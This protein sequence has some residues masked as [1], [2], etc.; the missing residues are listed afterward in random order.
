MSTNAVPLQNTIVSASG[1]MEETGSSLTKCL[2]DK[3]EKHVKC[4]IM[5]SL[6][7]TTSK[8]RKPFYRKP[9]TQKLHSSYDDTRS[10]QKMTES[11]NFFK[12]YL[13]E[14][15]SAWNCQ[16]ISFRLLRCMPVTSVFRFD[17]LC[18]CSRQTVDEF[19][20]VPD[21]IAE[22]VPSRNEKLQ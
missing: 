8:L 12:K 9:L 15:I 3:H 4:K 2:F 21:I 1:N 16:S 5:T 6:Q 18:D 17:V 19:R 7:Q 10:W 13:S 22:N 14:A 20:Q 11:N